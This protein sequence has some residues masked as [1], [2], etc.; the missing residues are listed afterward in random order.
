MAKST[1]LLG[2]LR[3][4]SASSRPG[5]QGAAFLADVGVERGAG[6]GL[7]VEGGQ[8]QPFALV[9]GTLVTEG[10]CLDEQ[11]GEHGCA[12]SDRECAGRPGDGVGE[13]VTFDA[14]LHGWFLSISVLRLRGTALLSGSLC[15]PG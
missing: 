7:V 3:Q 4:M 5:D 2:R 9:A 12:G 11:A 10:T 6:R 15:E 1:G 13:N 8:P 14:E